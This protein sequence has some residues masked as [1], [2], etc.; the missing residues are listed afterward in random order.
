VSTRPA[1]VAATIVAVLLGSAALA[2]ES[3]WGNFT[4]KTPSAGNS[5]TAATDFRAPSASASVIGKTGGGTVGYVKKAGT[6]YV[7]ANVSDTGS[8]ASGVSTVTANVSAITST[9]TAVALSAGSFTVGGVTYNRRSAA[10]T[11]DSGLAAGSYGYSLTMTDV[12]GNSKT[13]SGYAVTVDNTVPTGTD[14][15]A[16]NAG[17][18]SGLAEAGDKITFTYSKAIDPNSVLSGWNSGST[19]VVV[20]LNN[21]SGA[22]NDTLTVFNATNASQLP[23]GSINLG[24]VD[25]TAASITFGATGTASS[26]VMSGTTITITLGTQSAAATTAA[27]TG[28]MSW[29]PSATATDVAGNGASTAAVTESG[30]ADTEF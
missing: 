30:T 4:A 5:I 3:V 21:G 18:T 10:V 11:A 29:T 12:A 14:V 28:T 27:G 17:V 25:Y 9:G 22:S 19:N 8:P 6:Y 1:L 26:M 20:R 15:Q 2:H 23:L 7:Y 16:V 24:R 13:Q